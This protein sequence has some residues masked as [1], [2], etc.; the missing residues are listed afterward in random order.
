MEGTMRQFIL[1][2]VMGSVVT[3]TVVGAGNLYDSKGNVQ[4]PR[5]ST[6]QFDYFRQRQQQLD[7]ENMRKQMDQQESNR[8]YDQKKPC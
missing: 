4:A 1:G 6:Q 3:G 5:G 2:L 7:V 8:K